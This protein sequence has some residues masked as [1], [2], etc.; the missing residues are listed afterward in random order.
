MPSVDFSEGRGDWL[1]TETVKI[2]RE[3]GALKK[4]NTNF[5]N[6]KREDR[7]DERGRRRYRD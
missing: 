3:E 7:A 1:L 5:G 6:R 4:D 2:V